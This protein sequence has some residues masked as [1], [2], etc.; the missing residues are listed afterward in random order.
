VL[1]VFVGEL[2]FVVSCCFD[3]FFLGFDRSL[4]VVCVGDLCDWGNYYLWIS[5]CC[6]EELVCCLP[7]RPQ[8]EQWGRM[9]HHP[10]PLHPPPPALRP[11]TNPAAT[12][13]PRSPPPRRRSP[14]RRTPASETP[15]LATTAPALPLLPPPGPR[16]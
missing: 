11:P 4:F 15:R 12:G 6:W 16:P 3:F 5:W 7:P 2:Y 1:G 8:R 13:P 10:P 14:A 9:R